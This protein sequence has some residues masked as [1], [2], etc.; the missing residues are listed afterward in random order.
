MT[1]SPFLL[2]QSTRQDRDL[3]RRAFGK[4]RPHASALS[5]KES[6]KREVVFFSETDD[7]TGVI[8]FAGR[9]PPIC[10]MS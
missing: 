1:L 2:S 4:M 10:D 5:A 9:L 8:R 7:V 6:I 3:A